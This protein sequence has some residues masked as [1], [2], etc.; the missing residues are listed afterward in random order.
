MK[1]KPVDLFEFNSN[2][3]ANRRDAD[4]QPR[5]LAWGL[6]FDDHQ[7]YFHEAGDLYLRVAPVADA[8]LDEELVEGLEPA[9]AMRLGIE[10]GRM[11]LG[12]AD[13]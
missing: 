3:H 13:E 6:S 2:G 5:V 9:D 4:A 1:Y 12:G 10:Y 11:R 7:F 8:V